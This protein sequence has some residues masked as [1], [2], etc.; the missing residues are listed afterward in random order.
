[1][2]GTAWPAKDVTSKISAP[3]SQVDQFASADPEGC[4]QHMSICRTCRMRIELVLTLHAQETSSLAR[5]AQGDL[6]A[7]W[8]HRNAKA[9]MRNSRDAS[10]CKCGL[11]ATVCL[12][13]QR[14]TTTVA[15][16]C[17]CVGSSTGALSTSRVDGVRVTGAEIKLKIW[18]NWLHLKT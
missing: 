6:E 17:K 7:A 15:Q 18:I 13:W 9:V 8:K 16:V 12:R 10:K 4:R 14:L 3:T 1:M 5:F 2:K 11:N